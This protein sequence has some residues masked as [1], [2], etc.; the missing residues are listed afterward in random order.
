MNQIDYENI[1]TENVVQNI[2]GEDLIDSTSGKYIITICGKILSINGRMFWNSRDQAIKSFYNSYK[3]RVRRDIL[4]VL[5]PHDNL[6][7]WWS[8]SN[9]GIIWKAF[10]QVLKEKFNFKITKV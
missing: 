6:F 1:I 10:K 2:F 7:N 4:M 3:W 8:D 9:G 5:H